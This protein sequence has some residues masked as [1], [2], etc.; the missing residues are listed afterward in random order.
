MQ[1]AAAVASKALN[2]VI[3]Y[4]KK[5]VSQWTPKD[6]EDHERETAAKKNAH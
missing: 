2:R 3:E 1:P 5:A 4:S 6:T